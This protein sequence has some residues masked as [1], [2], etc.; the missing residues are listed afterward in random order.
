MSDFTC[1]SEI[2]CFYPIYKLLIADK[3]STPGVPNIKE[4]TKDSAT[5]EWTPPTKDGGNPISNYVIEYKPVSGHKWLPANEDMKVTDTS[6]TIKDLTED[7]E[8]EF[9]VAAENR[10][11]VS[12]PSA[13]SKKATVKEEIGEFHYSS[14]HEFR[15]A[16]ENRAGVSKPSAP[17]K[18]A[19]VKEEIG[20]FC[21]NTIYCMCQASVAYHYS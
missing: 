14:I 3:P 1:P 10:A 4:L 7:E 5:I 6:F 16:A 13:P 20:E 2:R 8:Y 11:G 21:S 17:S 15:V 12:K 9:R 18:K 19:T